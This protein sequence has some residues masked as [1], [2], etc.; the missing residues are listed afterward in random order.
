MKKYSVL[1]VGGGSTYTP[2][3]VLMLLSQLDRFPLRK[4]KLYDNDPE[5]QQIIADACGGI[6]REKAPQIEFL[7]TSDPEEAYTDI[8]F[9]MA[10]IRV[11]K[12]AMRELDE[13][14]PLKY[15]VVGQETCGPGGIAYGMRSIGGIV[16]MGFRG[17]KLLTAGHHPNF[18]INFFHKEGVPDL[19]FS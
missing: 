14:I 10:Q 1:I 12:Y 9:A 17:E 18:Y 19:V 13:K 2:G 7:A 5:R 6:I 3:I 8:D 16:M 15:D 4:L 11:G